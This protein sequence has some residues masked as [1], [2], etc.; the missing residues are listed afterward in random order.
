ML[1]R[2]VEATDA[3]ESATAFALFRIAIGLVTLY[4]IGD[5]AAR[6]LA[7]VLWVGAAHGGLLPLTEVP[8]LFHA[9]GGATPAVTRGLVGAALVGAALVTLGVGG[10]PL[11]AATGAVVANLVDV[12]PHAGGSSDEL[13]TTAWWLLVLGSGQQTLS[14]AARWRSGQWFPAATMYAFPRWL[15][16]WQLCLMYGTTGLQIVSAYWVPGGESS[17]L[18]YILQQPTWHRADMAWVA[19][20]YPLTQLATT[21]TW[22]W[23]VLAF[24]WIAVL[25]WSATPER[26]GRLRA[27]SNRLGVRW[28]FAAVGVVLHLLILL[29]LE[30]GPFSP[31]SLSFY[32]C[33]VHPWEWDRWFGRSSR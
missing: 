1:R 16:L 28:W 15:A 29:T 2:W 7:P 3:T 27:A 18:Y 4:T 30:V 31:L 6:G 26:P 12:N 22:C 32:L 20:L 33:A 24:G 19:P 5:V 13:L 23:E 21:I 9:L 8:W 10:R 17:A 11:T 14:L 25:W